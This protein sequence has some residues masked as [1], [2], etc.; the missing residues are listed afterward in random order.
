M[1]KVIW[2][3]RYQPGMDREEVR[4]WWRDQHGTL[5]AATPGMVRYVQNHWASALDPVTELP[6]DERPGFDGHAE[7]WFT[8]RAAYEA[9]MAS[10]HWKRVLADGPNGFDPSSLVGGV[11]LENVV[12]WDARGDDRRYPAMGEQP[13]D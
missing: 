2:L 8:D 6:T 7:H 4:R 3:V 5:G 1:Y 11:L 10:D 13:D 9:A 12:T